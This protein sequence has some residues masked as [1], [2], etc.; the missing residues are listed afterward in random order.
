M[1][2]YNNKKTNFQKKY[3]RIKKKYL[4]LKK[5][6]N[7]YGG[8]IF[9][10]DK[11][12]H[13]TPFDEKQYQYKKGR[14]KPDDELLYNNTS[15]DFDID[16]SWKTTSYNEAMILYYILE[17]TGVHKNSTNLANSHL[18]YKYVITPS[19]RSKEYSFN[20]F[21]FLS[22]I[23]KDSDKYN[24]R[25]ILKEDF[26][27]DPTTNKFVYIND[28]WDD[29]NLDRKK[30]I[31]QCMALSIH[32][33][34][35]QQYFFWKNFIENYDNEEDKIYL[36]G[37][38]EDIN[39]LIALKF[40]K[41][42]RFGNT[43]IETFINHNDVIYQLYEYYRTIISDDTSLLH[44]LEGNHTISTDNP[45]WLQFYIQKDKKDCITCKKIYDQQLKE[46]EKE[47]RKEYEREKYIE[48]HGHYKQLPEE[49]V[50]G[51]LY[52]PKPVS[53][54]D[55]YNRIK[56]IANMSFKLE[57]GILNKIEEILENI[58]LYIIIKVEK[59]MIQ[60]EQE[61]L[62]HLEISKRSEKHRIANLINSINQT[63]GNVKEKTKRIKV[64]QEDLEKFNSNIS[65]DIRKQKIKLENASKNISEQTMDIEETEFILSRLST[66]EIK[67]I[68]KQKKK[69]ENLLERFKKTYGLGPHE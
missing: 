5:K 20:I 47:I 24:C 2:F 9:I 54:P 33:R 50:E 23:Q 3:F 42:D 38:K 67:K 44:I 41:F 12:T 16:F 58:D 59:D 62:K 56:T 36:E 61:T 51:K 11:Y 60:I 7:Y 57:D 29:I 64:I 27:N 15:I 6:L 4:E 25:L 35:D 46:R 28:L 53:S 18:A 22:G 52:V 45:L 69:I 8:T 49:L 1:L 14:S 31:V 65:N 26:E 37:N 30:I 63:P 40:I 32:I 48:T 19:I 43:G 34:I 13:E 39:K 10:K 17:G 68:G 55:V 21:E 66:R